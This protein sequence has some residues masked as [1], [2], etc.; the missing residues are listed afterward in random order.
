VAYSPTF[1]LDCW[2]HRLILGYEG[3]LDSEHYDWLASHDS[4][5]L[6][7]TV[8]FSWKFW[9]ES[10]I[11]VR[12]RCECG[13]TQEV[14]HPLPFD[15]TSTPERA[16]L[17]LDGGW[18]T[19]DNDSPVSRWQAKYQPLLEASP[20]GRYAILRRVVSVDPPKLWLS[21]HVLDSSQYSV[22]TQTLYVTYPG[23]RLPSPGV[24]KQ[25]VYRGPS[26]SG[27]LPAVYG[28]AVQIAVG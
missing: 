4:K 21:P 27:S 16:A 28:P 7:S 5:C 14:T 3:R 9:L 12:L 8:T 15:T 11:R 22:S 26:A 10:S 19:Q 25:V 13:A 2:V 17:A 20:H 6:V 24:A 1:A 23:R 18:A